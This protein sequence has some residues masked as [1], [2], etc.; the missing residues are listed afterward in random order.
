MFV[1]SQSEIAVELLT[2]QYIG[3]ITTW[4]VRDQGS[5]AVKCSFSVNSPL[6]DCIDENASAGSNNYGLYGVWPGGE[7][8]PKQF[9][10][11]GL[12]QDSTFY[13][14]WV[15]CFRSISDLTIIPSRKKDTVMQ[16]LL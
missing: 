9:T 10:M 15:D 6:K 12:S 3:P 14:I 7:W 16:T 13:Q 1:L 4:E 11:S 8:G 2:A 5:G